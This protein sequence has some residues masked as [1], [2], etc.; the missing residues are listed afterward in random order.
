MIKA[1]LVEPERPWI[2]FVEDTESPDAI[3]VSVALTAYDARRIA[4]AQ[5]ADPKEITVFTRRHWRECGVVLFK[6]AW[7]ALMKDNAVRPDPKAE[8]LKLTTKK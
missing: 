2:V 5:G 7:R 3:F 4:M 6:R 8:K 1:T